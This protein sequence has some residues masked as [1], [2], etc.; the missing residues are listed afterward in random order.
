MSVSGSRVRVYELAKELKL[1][2]KR[3]I[4]ELRREGADVTVPSNSVSKELADKVRNRYFA[5]NQ[6]VAA[7]AIKVIK[8]QRSAETEV[9]SREEEKPIVTEAEKK[10]EP[11]RE[12]Q[13]EEP[14]TILRTVKVIRKTEISAVEAQP[15]RGIEKPEQTVQTT[16]EAEISKQ[17]EKSTEERVT[18]TDDKRQTLAGA[19]VKQLKLRKDA[20]SAGFKEGEKVVFEP[21]KPKDEIKTDKKRQKFIKGKKEEKR[22][23]L[24]ATP[25]ETP[26]PQTVYFPKPG[27]R[28]PVGRHDKKAHRY[29]KESKLEEKEIAHYQ[30]KTI[31]Q[32]IFEQVGKPDAGGLRPLK[33][34]EGT[35]VRDF[36]E[37]LGVIPKDMVQFLIKQ[38]I[39]ATINQ[40]LS[41]ND[42]KKIGRILGF[43]ITVVP[44][45]E[46]IQEEDFLKVV[47][48]DEDVVEVPRAPVVT[49]MGHVDHG[50]TSLLDAIRHTNVAAGEAGGI[51]QHIGA[52]S[53]YVPDP[54]DPE[55]TR[56]IVFL[57]TPGHEA[58]TMMRARGA[59]VTDIVI[60]VV[61][62][63]D[64]VM[65]QT[66]E[67][68]EH[69]K[70]AGVPIIVAINKI[71]KPDAN[72]E[73]VKQEL[74]LQGLQPV[75]WGGNTE[76]IPISAK[77]RQNLEL[78]LETVI[79]QADIME[80]KASPSL[81]AS[82]VVLEAK[83]DKGRGP[84]AT[85]LVQQGTLRIGDPFIVGKTY[86][87]VRA[88]FSD[89]GESLK[90]APPST[91][92]EVLGIEE[93]PQAGD[94]FQV[95]TDIEQAQEIARERQLKA[96][97]ADLSR[98]IRRGIELLKQEDVKELLVILKADVQGSI[99]ALR[100][101]LEKLSTE[102]VKVRVI[103]AGLGAITESDVLLASATQADSK[104]TA[105]VIIG[106]NVRPEARAAE[107]AKQEGVEIRLHSIIYK[108]EEE[109]KAA[110]IGMLDTVEKEVILGKA[111]VQQTFRVPKV[112]TVAGCL[113]VEGTIK[114]SSKARL[115]RDG[116]RVWE[117]DIASLKRF[118]EDVSEVRAG[119]ECGIGLLN[120]NDIKVGDEIESFTLEKIAATEL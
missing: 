116:V 13:E 62:A 94:I 103:R 85:V 108:V 15:A 52:Y 18:T 42:L 69:A 80:L 114:R 22:T 63:D 23:E 88:M 120:F 68:I 77:K 55:K 34:S 25:G 78:L 47:E 39:F 2:T 76:M 86:G 36:A 56:R 35:T 98:T 46:A 87:K 102:K 117:G 19:Q 33:L 43:D 4:E 83:L 109:I 111:K 93:V 74:A 90:E 26:T 3:V 73:R 11:K 89:R 92:V 65:P 14:R 71:D 118:K 110:M 10:V 54:D 70:A 96:R 17:E 57:D 79:L 82:G 99:E 24:K 30:P 112:G 41:E 97:T 58:F 40:Q 107:I 44:F 31:E 5:P 101:S 100:P 51:T 1:D 20:I 95:V 104:Q 105:V 6:P 9:P 29:Q 59:R 113:V 50:K 72:V 7:K 67:A 21:A 48:S 61:A 91:P 28:R 81:R 119:F 115:F 106:F 32:K 49:V 64:G 45:E 75:E 12:A 84:V 53:V 38:G 16:V 8:K 27:D 60:L 37:K 66:I